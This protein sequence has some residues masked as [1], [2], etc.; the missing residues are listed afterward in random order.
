[1]IHSIHTAHEDGAR[2]VLLIFLTPE[3]VRSV[4]RLVCELYPSIRL[5]VWI[6]SVR[7]LLKTRSRAA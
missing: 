3:F 7:E 6:P 5:D 4:P 2:I 1:M